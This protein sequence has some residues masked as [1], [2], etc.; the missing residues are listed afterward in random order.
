MLSKRL[1]NL[2]FVTTIGPAI[3]P[4]SFMGALYGAWRLAPMFM[5]HAKLSS[6]LIALLVERPFLGWFG[7]YLL[8]CLMFL[9]VAKKMLTCCAGTSVD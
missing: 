2:L 5:K 7:K 9:Y 8:S 3:W 4:C 6:S 1:R